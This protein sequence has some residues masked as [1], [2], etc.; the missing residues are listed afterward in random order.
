VPAG[1]PGRIQ[2]PADLARPGVKI[3]AAGDNVPIRRYATQ[4]VANLAKV[5]G[6]PADFA[7]AYAANVVSKE[8][9][10]TSVL[11]KVELG[12]GDAGIVY[13]TDARASSRVTAIPIPASANVT[14]TYGGV[15]LKASANQVAATAFLT[16]LA[17]P[18]G[19]AILATFGFRP[20]TE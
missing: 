1:N 15:V 9:N 2:S 7:S 16:W 4:L 5:A 6:Y 8:D 18:D 12:E 19:H 3:I 20:P 14:A 11:A 13:A 17:S 10:V